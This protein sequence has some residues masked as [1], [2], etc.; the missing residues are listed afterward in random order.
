MDIHAEIER[1]IKGRL[2]QKHRKLTSDLRDHIAALP[3]ERYE[4][5]C[6][7]LSDL[8]EEL[9]RKNLESNVDEVEKAL[10]TLAIKEVTKNEQ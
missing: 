3:L 2:R 4:H 6:R 1:V 10:I 8:E 9:L 5:W 7:V